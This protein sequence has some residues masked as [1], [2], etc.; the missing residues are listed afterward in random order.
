MWSNDHVFD[1]LEDRMTEEERLAAVKQD[2]NV[3]KYTDPRRSRLLGCLDFKSIST[4]RCNMDKTPLFTEFVVTPDG[5]FVVIKLEGS[6]PRTSAMKITF[7]SRPTGYVRPLPSVENPTPTE[8]NKI[9]IFDVVASGKSPVGVTSAV[10]ADAHDLLRMLALHLGYTDRGD[11]TYCPPKPETIK[12]TIARQAVLKAWHAFAD[13]TVSIV[14][15]DR[16]HDEAKTFCLEAGLD[17]VV[18]C[19]KLIDRNIVHCVLDS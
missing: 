6:S 4:P 14:E 13:E 12:E 8:E 2:P 19:Q 16:I 5:S 1:W 3:I 7:K 11:K 15:Y 9:E 10:N 18:E 17:Y